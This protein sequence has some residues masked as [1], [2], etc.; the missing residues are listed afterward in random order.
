MKH[1]FL[2]F[3][4]ILI[5]TDCHQAKKPDS[6]LQVTVEGADIKDT[7]NDEEKSFPAL[8]NRLP[9]TDIVIPL[10]GKPDSKEDKELIINLELLG[11]IWGFLKYHH[12]EVGKGKYDWDNELFRFLP[13][14]V[15]VNDIGQRDETLLQWIDKY[16][17][18]PPCTTCQETAPD[19]FLKPDF[20]WIENGNMKNDLKEKIMEIYRNRLQE[21]LYYIKI[22]NDPFYYKINEKPDSFSSY[23]S[24]SV[25]L[26]TLYRY[27]NIIQYF[28]PYKY[29]TDKN[30]ND[31]L[32]ESKY[33]TKK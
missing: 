9:Y 4:S 23:P 18:I 20:S 28:F 1:I 21:E 7:K 24:T 33:M 13:E 5:T 15:N 17:E 30:W 32:K 8:L 29:L 25:R 6:E 27:W 26:L 22:A 10:S 16:G 12:P 19:A 11:R 3:L 14:Y 31:V 2:F